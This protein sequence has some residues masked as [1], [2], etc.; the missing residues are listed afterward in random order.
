MPQI[1][2]RLFRVIPSKDEDVEMELRKLGEI[3][4]TRSL[5]NNNVEYFTITKISGDDVK[6]AIVIKGDEIAIKNEAQLLITIVKSSFNTIDV[7][8]QLSENPLIRVL[9]SFKHFF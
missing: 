8:D 3:I 9:S 6:G 4:K 5:M 1:T 2:L 7:E